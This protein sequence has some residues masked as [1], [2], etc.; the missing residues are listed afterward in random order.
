[1]ADI[2]NDIVELQS[3]VFGRVMQSPGEEFPVGVPD[4]WRDNQSPGRE[5]PMVGPESWRDNQ[6]PDSW[7]ENQDILVDMGSG[8]DKPKDYKTRNVAK[9]NSGEDYK[10]RRKEEDRNRNRNRKRKP[11]RAS[12]TDSDLDWTL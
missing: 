12:T 8:E 2:R 10:P 9:G 7:R 3:K 5:V 4:T 6:S 11:M 1:M